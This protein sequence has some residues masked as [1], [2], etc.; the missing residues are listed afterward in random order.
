MNGVDKIEQDI[1]FF[2]ELGHPNGCS[3]VR[4]N[5]C[6]SLHQKNH[7]QVVS[8]KYLRRKLSFLDVG[9]FHSPF[10]YSFSNNI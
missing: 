5:E 8:R 7:L 3:G 4:M 10:M 2:G 9:H 6:E 1:S